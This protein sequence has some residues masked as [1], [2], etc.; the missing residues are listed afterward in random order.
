MMGTTS[1]TDVEN[2]YYLDTVPFW[3]EGKGSERGVKGSGGEG[4]EWRGTTFRRFAA[5]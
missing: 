5:A 3:S 4:W 1:S 2:V